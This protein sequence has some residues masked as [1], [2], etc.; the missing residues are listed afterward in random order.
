MSKKSFW[1]LAISLAL[2]KLLIHFLTCTNYELHRDEML[3]LSMGNHLSWGFA[4]TPPFMS[5]LSFIIIHVFGYHEFFVKLFP[6]L[7]G[8][9]NIILVAMFIREL[10][11]QKTAVLTGCLAYLLST[12]MLRTSSLFMPVIFELFFWMLLLY[13]VLKLIKSK[14][15]EYWIWIGICFGLA[16]LNKYSVLF[17]GASIFFGILISEHRKLLLSK[18]LVYGAIAGLL[19]MLPNLLWQI[20]HNFAVVTHMKELYRTQLVYV[21]AKAFFSDQIFMNFPAILIWTAGFIGIIINKQEKQYRLFA[22]IQVILISLFLVARGKSYYTLG[23]YTPMF[24][25]GGY[26]LEKYL[27]KYVSTILVFSF[28]LTLTE[29]PLGLPVLKQEAMKKYCSLFGK[30]ITKAP[31]RSENNEYFPIPQDY[32]DMT[33]WNELAKLAS[34]AYN[35]LS[36][37]EKKGC[38]VY[39]NN[40]GQAGAFD[41]YGKRYNLPAPV[42]VNDSYIFWAPDSLTS[43]NFIISDDQP[44]DIPRLFK[45]YREIG[46]IKNDCFRENGLKVFLCQDP[47]P[48]LNEFFKKRISEHKKVYGY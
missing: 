24:A 31:M 10:G 13:F 32:M 21:S 39:A 15:P 2:F 48:A 19:I 46:E 9:F 16:F 27:K 34:L 28:L 12:A 44:G 26:V 5:L 22:Y 1:I 42:S 40:Y 41:F 33:G 43:R 36:P 20:K 23:I 47:D 7:F 6:A 17:L 30:Y 3:Y 4:S 29:L 8:A 38:T 25:F 45:T 37:E 11:G 14:N 18:Y 35:E